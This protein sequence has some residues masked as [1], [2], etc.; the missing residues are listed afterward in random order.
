M[1]HNTADSAGSDNQSGI[2]IFLLKNWFPAIADQ[3]IYQIYP[4]PLPFIK[5]FLPSL[6]RFHQ[7]GGKTGKGSRLTA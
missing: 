4:V 6:I 3:L 2:H 7:D 5:Y 1:R